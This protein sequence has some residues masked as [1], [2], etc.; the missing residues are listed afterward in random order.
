VFAGSEIVASVQ[1]IQATAMHVRKWPWES[2]TA[3][4]AVPIDTIVG[5]VVYRGVLAVAI[6]PSDRL[7]LDKSLSKYTFRLALASGTKLN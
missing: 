2:Y 4:D 3:P 5:S 6:S 1:L 7:L